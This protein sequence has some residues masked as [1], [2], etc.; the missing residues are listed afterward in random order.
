M[1]LPTPADTS[2]D[3]RNST[4]SC[5]TAPQEL[6]LMVMIASVQRLLMFISMSL[7]T[8]ANTAGNT[9][10]STIFC[11]TATQASMPM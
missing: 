1:S 4:G 11:R 8:P 7:P 5:S 6:T 9:G 2:W 3:T 10:S